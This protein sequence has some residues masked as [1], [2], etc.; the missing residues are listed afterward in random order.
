M[1]DMKENLKNKIEELNQDSFF[2]ELN[3]NIIDGHEFDESEYAY[4]QS[5]CYPQIEFW[6]D[7]I[8]KQEIKYGFAIYISDAIKNKDLVD[9]IPST[10]WIGNTNKLDDKWFERIIFEYD[11]ENAIQSL[12]RYEKGAEKNGA[13][14]KS[15]KELAI[16][17]THYRYIIFYL[18]RK[19][20]KESLKK[21]KNVFTEFLS[22]G[23]KIMNLNLKE[24]VLSNHNVILHGAPGTGKT[25]LAKKIAQ[26]I[27]FGGEIGKMTDNLKR[28]FDEQCGFVQFHQSYD[29]TDFVE[30]LRPVN[31]G[32][33]QIGF[34]RMDG[35]FKAFCEKALRSSKINGVD[36]FEES[37]NKLL[38]KFENNEKIEV[39]KLRK[40]DALQ[41][42]LNKGEDGLADINAEENHRY[43]SKDQCYNVYRGRKGTPAGS[44]DN[45]RKAIIAYMKKNVGLK[46]Y[47]EGNLD[48]KSVRKYVFI[49]DE[50][51]R[52]EISKIFGELFYSV[53]PGYRVSY[54]DLKKKN[55]ISAIRTQYANLQD[56]P[57][58]F[59]EI[60]GINTPNNYG[61]F[62]VPENVYIIGTMNDIDRSVESLDFAMRRRFAFAEIK[63]VDCV[64]MLY[65]SENGIKKY[66]KD[67][68]KRMNA[69]NQAINTVGLSHAF[70]IGP[71]YFLKLEK[72]NGNFQMLWDLH[73][74]GVVKEYLRGI[75]DDGEKYKV[76]ENAFFDSDAKS[77]NKEESE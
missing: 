11:S 71:A 32:Q 52:G 26:E 49:I 46:E 41:V 12:K 29:Y 21:F 74:K 31:Q 51:N 40:R 70:D 3:F 72:Y 62:F 73:I 15:L 23:E 45:Y 37:W 9:F 54:D 75:D 35:V 56:E 43:F 2:K 58:D 33:N 28:Q 76:L 1:A 57:N 27:I 16:S 42:V 39:P 38:G 64:T 60:M 61:H 55:V 25:F 68:E 5:D 36:N 50:I 59:D 20:E 14:E 69:L 17:D 44:L 65:N 7:I 30:G 63:A 6:A 19:H 48:N 67:A 24:L 53:D 18:K 66:A 13:G 8:K 4:A 47:V 34:K 22:F 77:S 10:W